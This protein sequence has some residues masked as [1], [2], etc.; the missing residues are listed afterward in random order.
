[1]T[2]PLTPAEIE[3]VVKLYGA[4]YGL[5]DQSVDP[6]IV[7]SDIQGQP[8]Y[9]LKLLTLAR[10][11]CGFGAGYRAG[12]EDAGNACASISIDWETCKHSE[13]EG[14]QLYVEAA[15]ECTD[16]VRALTPP[17][18]DPREEV[19]AGDVERV[20]RALCLFE[21]E[22]A[23]SILYPEQ[24]PAWHEFIPQARAVIAALEPTP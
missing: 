5:R 24:C 7:K 15:D 2:P 1:M 21:Y 4:F 12:V 10:A 22:D 18:E 11:L 17:A 13:N 16:A 20:A 6:E 3:I 9:A 8:E 14:W 23:D 19:K